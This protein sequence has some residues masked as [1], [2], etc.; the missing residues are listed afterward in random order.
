M[1]HADLHQPGFEP[2]QRI[3][4]NTRGK[5]AGANYHGDHKIVVGAFQGGK[6]YVG[7]LFVLCRELGLAEA[8]R[9]PTNLH[10][11]K[12]MEQSAQE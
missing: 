12:K 5:I 11:R 2:L 4:V 6:Q 3:S 10:L 8:A 7:Q 9:S 1:F